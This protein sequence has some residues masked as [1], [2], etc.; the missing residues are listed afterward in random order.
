MSLGIDIGKF[1][2][3]IVELVQ[4]KDQVSI[5]NI[6]EKNIFDDLNKSDHD[7]ITKSQISACIQ[8][9][10]KEMNLKP[11]KVKQLTS[12]LS[13]KAIDIRQI[14]TLEMPDHELIVSL[15]LEAKKHVPLDGTDAVIDY[16]FIFT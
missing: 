3:K 12:S 16:H 4:I 13:G 8:D 9:L 6:G 1:S 5:K 2:V 14:T 10:C 11:R 7:K 15:E